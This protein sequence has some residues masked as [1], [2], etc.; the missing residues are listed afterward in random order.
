MHTVTDLRPYHRTAV[1]ASVDIVS[2]VTLH[3]LQRQTP[4][5]GWN[6]ADLL[7]HMTV[8]HRGFAAAAQGGGADAAIW[9]PATVA[10][11]IA[12]DPAGIYSAAAAAVLEAFA[13]DSVLDAPFA[14]P[15]FGPGATFPG[16]IAIGFHFIDYVVH[17]WDVATAIG[18]AFDL[19]DDVLAAALPLA[20][21]VPEGDFRTTDGA[22]FGPAN[23]VIPQGGD[24][25]RILCHLGRSP[26]WA[27]EKVPAQSPSDGGDSR[28]EKSRHDEN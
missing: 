14:L 4:C 15:D 12:V 18:T 23:V 8:Q 6:L 13:A 9:R 19:P 2:R 16:S 3:D 21:A 5:A 1:L 20:L 24:L 27:F 25:S 28:P 11:A 22:P 26:N 7:A 10:K 17:G